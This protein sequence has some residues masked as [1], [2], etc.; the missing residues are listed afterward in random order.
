VLKKEYR[1]GVDVVYESVGGEMFKT[2][3]D[4]LAFK[5][6]LVIIGMMSQ[7]GDGWPID[8]HPGLPE[9]LLKKSAS[10]I[11]A[12]LLPPTVLCRD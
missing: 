12:C 10:L 5:G 9:K 1:S 11:G 6:R 4:A 2:A 7:Y 3:V 8:S